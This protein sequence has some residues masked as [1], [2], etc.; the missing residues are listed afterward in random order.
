MSQGEHTSASTA[1][2]SPSGKPPDRPRRWPSRLLRL[3]ACLVLALAA[4]GASFLALIFTR[5]DSAFAPCSGWIYTP[6]LI[7]VGL[8]VPAL[9]LTALG[10]TRLAMI[11]VG[12]VVASYIAT[13]IVWDPLDQWTPLVD[14][15]RY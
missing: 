8:T 7:A 1:G 9:V 15:L 13:W 3:A 6:Y 4:L 12:A 5:G 10:A 2:S 11:L 14:C